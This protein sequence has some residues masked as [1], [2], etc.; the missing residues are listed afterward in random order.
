MRI[1]TDF[2][3]IQHFANDASG[4]TVGPTGGHEF[5]FVNSSPSVLI[6]P[7]VTK[8]F[9]PADPFSDA[10]GSWK[11]WI[12]SGGYR[13]SVFDL[14]SALSGGLDYVQLLKFETL[15][16]PADR[17]TGYMA[18]GNKTTSTL[19]PSSGTASFAGGTRGSYATGAI[20]Y[21]TASDV[22][23]SVN[24]G[25]NAVTGAAT[26]FRFAD[27]TGVLVAAPVV[28]DFTFSGSLSTDRSAFDA[29]VT[30]A[31]PFISGRVLGQLYG[32]NLG[33]PEEAGLSYIITTGAPPVTPDVAPPVLFG[34]GVL[35]RTP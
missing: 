15:A 16:F 1:G 29:P 22:T 7:V 23:L 34:G 8:N 28:A 20:L 21:S 6:P 3:A 9:V 33:G 5:R 4:V 12:A 27:S 11:Q 24:F 26:N 32:P 10:L 31:A 17:L 30:A 25:S 13:F 2:S 18:Y 35:D 14:S 19:I